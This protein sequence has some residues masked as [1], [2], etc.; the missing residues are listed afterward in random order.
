MRWRVGNGDRVARDHLHIM[1]I[2]FDMSLP[3]KSFH[4]ITNISVIQALRRQ[5]RFPGYG[6]LR[7]APEAGL[8][9]LTTPFN[10]GRFREF[11]HV[12]SSVYGEKYE[13]KPVFFQRHHDECPS[14]SASCG[15]PRPQ[16]ERKA[17]L[18]R[19]RFSVYERF[20]WLPSV[21]KPVK[22]S[23]QWASP[24]FARRFISYRDYPVARD[25]MKMCTAS[26]VFIVLEKS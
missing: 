25:D 22:A 12:E 2:L 1:G 15:R 20:I 7:Q 19:L 3:Q 18:R 11:Q 8:Y 16:R 17:V 4:V 26:G 21:L 10:S 9:I 13:A 5:Y 6:A 24:Y 23:Y 14:R